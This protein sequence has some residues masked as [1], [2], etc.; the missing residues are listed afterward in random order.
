MVGKID[1]FHNLAYFVIIGSSNKK[2]PQFS[3]VGY[4][5]STYEGEYSCSSLL[6]FSEFF[7]PFSTIFNVKPFGATP[8]ALVTI[9]HIGRFGTHVCV[10]RIT[11][12]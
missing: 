8:T 7:L 10:D 12:R 4:K 11:N 6:K 1:A 9:P 5:A 2:I 3:I